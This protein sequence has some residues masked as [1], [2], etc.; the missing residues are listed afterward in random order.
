MVKF[1]KSSILYPLLIFAPIS[2]FLDQFDSNATLLF[3]VS[4]LALITWQ[5]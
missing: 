4:M 1:S 2:L 5:N 3:I